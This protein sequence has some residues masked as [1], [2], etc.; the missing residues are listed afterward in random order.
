MAKIICYGEEARHALER[1][2][3]QLADTVKITM[4]PKGRNVVL[5][6][7]F[8]A[9][10]ITN[11]GVTIAK[12]IELDDPFENMG[13][14]LVKEVSTKTNDVAGDG[15]TTA[16]LLAQAIIREGLKNL[17]AG[18]NPMV[19]KKG[20][21]KATATAVEAIKANSKKVNGSDD[22]ARVGTVSSGDETVG[23]LIAEAME[24]VSN[25]GVITVEESKTAETYSEVVEGMQF[26]RGY[27]TPYMVTDTEK[28]EAVLDDALILI[29]DKKISNIQELLPIL[30]QVVQSGKKLLVIAED[31]EGEALSTL[32][33]NKLRGT[34]N[35]VCVKAP[36]FGDRRKEM[37]EDIAVL[38]GGTVI[39]ADMGYELKEA[40]MDMLGKARQVKVSKE[41]TIIVDGAGSSEAIKNRTN[42]IR[43][44][45]ET[46]TSDYDREKLQER[47]AKMAG[48]VAIIRVGAATEVEMKEKKL[49][50]EDALNATRAAVEE[51]IVA[52]GGTAYVNAV[53]AVEKLLDETEGDE[54][55]GVRI[56]AKA[57]TEPMRQIAT[58]AGIDGSVV[59]ENVKKADKTGYGFDA[60]NE[61]YVDMIS[62]GIVDPT[63]V[64]RS[65]LENAASIAATL[66]TTEALVADKKEPAPAAPAAPDMGGMY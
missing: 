58:N 38:T 35:V 64:T 15:T 46:T 19:M 18:A 5:D 22:I 20:I 62:A 41:N 13:A 31:V 1:G 8:G 32:I 37:L 65:A 49:R 28:M 45:I 10:L 54:K 39:T 24:K 48:G 63:K 6:K 66:L 43:S 42:Q 57:L 3:N 33:V 21:A 51:G 4:G 14:Q 11:D 50:I 60:Y 27:I 47:L 23:K 25:D 26:D 7:K 59:L 44:Q 9:P 17:A 34:L 2:V 36:G 30:E 55:T 12:E 61:T 29:T 52:G 16:T 40:T 53:S 56:I